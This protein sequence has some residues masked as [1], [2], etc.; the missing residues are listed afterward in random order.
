MILDKHVWR[1]AD[2]R[3]VW[4]GDPDAAILA[5][6][7]GT[8]IPDNTARKLGLLEGEPGEAE[9][10]TEDLAAEVEALRAEN[11]ELRAKLAEADQSTPD[12]TAEAKAAAK[13]ADKSRA[14]PADK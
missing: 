10:P 13:P 8:E 12:G 9:V 1:T 6:A 14:K 3:L 11:A 2:Q 4:D 5:Y 7:K